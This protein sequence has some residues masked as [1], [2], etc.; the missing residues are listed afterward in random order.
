MNT[1]LNEK[2]MLVRL[3]VSQWTAKKY[4]KKVSSE[5]IQNNNATSK[6]GRFNKSLIAQEEINKINAIQ[7]QARLYHYAVTLPWNDE[8]SRILPSVL[9]M[10]YSKKMREFRSEFEGIVSEF[11]GKYPEL[12]EQAKTNLG[13]MFN[14]MDYPSVEKIKGKFAFGIDVYPMPIAS[15]F[16]VELQADEVESIR[17]DIETKTKTILENSTKDLYNRLYKVVSHLADKLSVTDAIFRNSI[18]S[19]IC[20]LCNLLPALNIT[21]DPKLEEIRKKIEERIC[22][23]NPDDFREDKEIRETTAKEAS[24]ILA[25]M[26]GYIG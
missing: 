22:D 8:G 26:E 20:D 21:N 18:I 23:K 12:K 24:D 7:Q 4:D 1:N 25:V 3:S 11:I 16:R 2:A 6:A 13:N 19:N 14:E 15:D 17:K 10:E 5:V 9:Y